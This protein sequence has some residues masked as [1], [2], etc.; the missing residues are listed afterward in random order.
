MPIVILP[1]PK[2]SPLRAFRLPFAA[3]YRVPVA[4]QKYLHIRVIGLNRLYVPEYLRQRQ[5]A[6]PDIDEDLVHITSSP[7]RMCSAYIW[8]YK[9]L[10]AQGDTG[11]IR[12][13]HSW[14]IRTKAS[15]NRMRSI[16]CTG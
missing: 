15:R 1:F 8:L 12:W 10:H 7:F 4:V 9:I 14:T 6:G 11:T 13:Q 3:D 16:G 5:I 2:G